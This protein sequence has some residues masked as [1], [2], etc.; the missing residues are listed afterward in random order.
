MRGL[1]RTP[2]QI[3]AKRAEKKSITILPAVAARSEQIDDS[4][5]N[6]GSFTAKAQRDLLEAAFKSLPLDDESEVAPVIP[7]PNL[8]PSVAPA[9]NA[10]QVAAWWIWARANVLKKTTVLKS[11][12]ALLIA[13]IL[14]WMP[15]QRLLATT[16]AEAIINARVIVVRAPIEGEVAAQADNLEVGKE[17]HRG[18]ELLTV[19]NPRSDQTYLGNLNRTKDQLTT[20]IAALQAKK[21]VLESHHSELAVQKE[22]YRASRIE[23]LERHISETDAGIVAAKAQHDVTAKALARSRELLHKGAVTEAFA[24]KAERDDSV[25]LETINGLVERRK[26]TQIELAAAQKGTFVSDGYNDTSES[27]QRG[28][29]VELQLADVDARLAGASHELTALNQD[30]VREEKRQ[31]KLST[32]VIHASISGRVWEVMTAPGE[33]V[34]AGQELMRIL[35]C[36]SAVVS[37]SVSE[38]VYQ[39]LRIGQPATFKP[40][41]SGNE[42]KGWIVGLT[43][44]AAVASNDAIQPK[45][46]SGAPYHVTVKFPTLYGK[47]GCQISRSGLVTFD[48]SNSN[49][50]EIA[51]FSDAQ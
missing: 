30:L 41:N 31:E 13:I 17:F 3:M 4:S 22:R 28:L 1:E 15:L 21:Q 50:V 6:E 12:V 47:A 25:A 26:A 14:G 33:H 9:G 35:D 45:A 23:Q 39:K 7:I 46:L 36:S 18:D 37:A 38:A 43:G 5:N 51:N 8:A 19:K 34:N 44:L 20:T 16:S 10:E 27:A 32:A 2:L 42:A 49:K 11:A 48:T 40:S 29:D 24:D